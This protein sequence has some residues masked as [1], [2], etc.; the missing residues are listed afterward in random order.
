MTIRLLLASVL[1]VSACGGGSKKPPAEPTT[2]TTTQPETVAQTAPE[3]KTEPA[4]PTPPPPPP[5]PKFVLGEAKIVLKST[6]KKQ[7]MAGEIAIAAD[8][9]INAT[10]TSGKKKEKKVKTGKL[11][12]EGELFDDKNE[13]IAKLGDD[14][15]VSALQVMVEK[16]D[17]QPEK[18]ESK[19]EELGSLNA[20]GVFTSK[21]DGKTFSVDDKGKI[22]GIPGVDLTVTA[23]AVEQK[24]AA[25]FVVVAMFGASSSTVEMKG[26]QAAPAAAP[27]KKK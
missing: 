25:V 15:T 5:A 24:K 6:D 16:V 11:T 23:A 13:V 26:A 10:V 27:A 7:P 14:G 8:G 9:T 17:G 1:V 4:E 18:R 20:E 2:T 19:M 22:A 12:A 21:K 3:E